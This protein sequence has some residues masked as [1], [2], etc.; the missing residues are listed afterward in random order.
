ML[1]NCIQIL[2]LWLIT[3]NL[4]SHLRQTYVSAAFA[5][6]RKFYMLHHSTL[7]LCMALQQ[8]AFKEFV[9]LRKTQALA[10][11][12]S[13]VF[14]SF[15][16]DETTLQTILLLSL[17]IRNYLNLHRI[18]TKL[19]LIDWRKGQS[20]VR[21]Q[22]C[23]EKPYSKERTSQRLTGGT[24]RFLLRRRKSCIFLLRWHKWWHFFCYKTIVSKDV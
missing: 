22:L 15:N 5:C 19:L 17:F 20:R 21:W 10:V 9:Q 12:H 11:T 23:H 3:Y 24:D 8:A 7:Y 4:S 14:L 18:V 2:N 1:G 13:V 6:K 16:N